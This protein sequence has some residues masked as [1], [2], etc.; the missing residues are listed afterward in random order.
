MTQHSCQG[1]NDTRYA[2]IVRSEWYFCSGLS[3]KCHGPP[4]PEYRTGLSWFIRSRGSFI[5]MTMT[6]WS[7]RGLIMP[8][9]MRYHSRRGQWSPCSK[10]LLLIWCHWLHDDW[11]KY[12]FDEKFRWPDEKQ[13]NPFR[14]TE[15]RTHGLKFQDVFACQWWWMVL[16]W[17]SVFSKYSCTQGSAD[18]NGLPRIFLF[19]KTRKEKN[20]PE[21]FSAC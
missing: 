17:L 8:R 21:I 10:V 15:W 12:S 6:W 14:Q 7:S 9:H 18:V 3:G 2:R 13:Q 1:R 19:L 20:W 5:R 16:T 4:P 11:K